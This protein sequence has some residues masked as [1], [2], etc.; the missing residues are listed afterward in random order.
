MAERAHA[1]LL[2]RL[3]AAGLAAVAV[4]LGATGTAAAGWVD[5]GLVSGSGASDLRL[6]MDAQGHAT[7]L[8][9]DSG[10]LKASGR[11]PGGS[12]SSLGTLSAAGTDPDLAVGRSGQ[13]GL[14]WVL[15]VTGGYL[16]QSA[17]RSGGGPITP[18]PNVQAAPLAAQPFDP[19]IDLD[20]D[21]DPT[22]GWI[23]DEDGGATFNRTFR[24]STGNVVA[25]GPAEEIATS[26]ILDDF[27]LVVD[28]A[29]KATL[30]WQDL[31]C[32]PMGGCA[33]YKLRAAVRPAGG[34]RGPVQLLDQ[35]GSDA[36]PA[37]P[38]VATDAAG[39]ATGI[40]HVNCQPFEPGLSG[41]SGRIR[42]VRHPVVRL[43]HVPDAELRQRTGRGRHAL[44]AC[45][46]GAGGRGLRGLGLP[47][48]WWH[49]SSRR[50]RRGPLG[51]ASA[52]R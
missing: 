8:W 50:W 18:F 28:G 16:V 17:K 5:A 29:G 21:G 43:G 13:V 1:R 30:L 35:T 33:D 32:I 49:A 14:V 22:V 6:A 15:P 39:N 2:G 36:I 24:V 48:R 46:G 40:W 19:Q 10:G 26:T 31:P 51:E 37:S 7:V 52:L 20:A 4:L 11:S 45:R 47:A 23:A 25:Y 27:D 42:Q 3:A 34:P 12:F 41:R 9:I 38:E 44:P